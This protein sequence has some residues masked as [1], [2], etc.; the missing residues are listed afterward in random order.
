MPAAGLPGACICTAACRPF[1][2][3]AR[4]PSRPT[5][6]QKRHC[7]P[8]NSMVAAFWC[9]RQMRCR[10]LYG[11]SSRWAQP[12]TRQAPF[13]GTR[14]GASISPASW[15]L[16]PAD[17]LAALPP[18]PVD[19]GMP[20]L[21]DCARPGGGRRKGGR[22]R[23]QRGSE[24][25]GGRHKAPAAGCSPVEPG[26]AGLARC[27]SRRLTRHLPLGGRDGAAGRPQRQPRLLQS[28]SACPPCPATVLTF[29]HVGAP[30]ARHR[31]R[32]GR[33]QRHSSPLAERTGREPPSV[34]R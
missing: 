11:C 9:T 1:A 6:W 31:G 26:R 20:A 3:A 29:H 33:R 24:L 4:C 10:W 34:G 25:A 17:R 22:G 19:C 14:R 16:P 5:C 28:H 2:T 27:I 32:R 30:S 12:G 13:P 15:P 7:R 23:L 21:P 18:A 8:S